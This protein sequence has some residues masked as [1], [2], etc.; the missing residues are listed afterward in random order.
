MSSAARET[1][2][3]LLAPAISAT[4]L[5]LED[6]QVTPAG[7]R[8]LVRVVVDKDGGVSL[9]EV[10][11]VSQAVSSVLDAD[12]LA[13]AALGSTPY[14]LEVSSPGVDRPLVQ[15]RHWRRALGRLVALTDTGGRQVRGRL[16]AA[17]GDEVTLATE[18]GE[19]VL[20]L[21]SVTRA[22]VEVEFA[23][24]EGDAAVRAHEGSERKQA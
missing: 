18:A 20:P 1:L 12:P 3:G 2:L 13:D 23:R 15:P 4:G 21:E 16:S 8:R 5:D 7:R 10:A 9:D 17:S 24:T 11:A 6:V 19:L 14:V 22:R